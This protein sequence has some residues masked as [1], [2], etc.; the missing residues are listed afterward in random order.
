[1]EIL[2][3][4]LDLPVHKLIS[5]HI[6]LLEKSLNHQEYVLAHCQPAYLS[7]L[8]VTISYFRAQRDR[9]LLGLTTVTIAVFSMQLCSGRS[10]ASDRQEGQLI[11][12]NI[13][14][15]RENTTPRRPKCNRLRT[16]TRRGFAILVFHHGHLLHVVLCYSCR[17]ARTVPEMEGQE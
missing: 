10:L 13:L 1:M 3:V 4:S 12:R 8:N 6:L 11:I 7:H 15:E 14:D 16:Y 5:D 17:I 2:K 9:I